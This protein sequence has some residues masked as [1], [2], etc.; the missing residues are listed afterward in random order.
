MSNSDDDLFPPDEPVRIK[1]KAAT[2]LP[3]YGLVFSEAMAMQI[4]ELVAS[5]FFKKLKETYSIKAKDRAA[6]KCLNSAQ[7]LE[8][9]MYWKGMAAAADIFFLDLEATRQ[10]FLAQSSDTNPKEEKKFKK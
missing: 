4:S 7:N 8:W 5:P 1:K 10:E 2:P 3:G 9:L 6:R